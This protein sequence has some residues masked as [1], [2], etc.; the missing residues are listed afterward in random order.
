MLPRLNARSAGPPVAQKA[1]WWLLLLFAALSCLSLAWA[2]LFT[3]A[4]VTQNYNTRPIE[5]LTLNG[6]V[7]LAAVAL[8]LLQT[9]A[10]VGLYMRR[11]WGRALATIAAAIWALTI[12]GIPFAALC[13][14]ALYRRWDPGVEA[15]F[16]KDHSSAPLYITILCGVA[17]AML[18]F[19]LWFLYLYLPPLLTSL[20]AGQTPKIDPSTWYALDTFALL[21]S[22]PLWTVTILSVVGLAQKHDFGAVLAVIVCVLFVLSG[23]G[24]LFGVAGLL[25]LWRWSHPALRAQ[26]A[27]A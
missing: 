26:P 8:T 18:V 24:V 14:F 23:V 22:L 15:T 25:V 6:F 1:P 2:A 13:V 5:N 16:D 10:L 19:W 11:H 27:M 12:I 20:T 9:T 17:A 3:A 4:F 7:E 21:L